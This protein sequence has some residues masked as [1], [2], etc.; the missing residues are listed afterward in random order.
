MA[1]KINSK[2]KNFLGVLKRKF[3]LN[4]VI[5]FGS[6]ARGDA[7]KES[8]YD[9]LIVSQDFKRTNFIDRPRDVVLACNVRFAADLLCYTPDEFEKKRAQISIVKTA[10]EEGTVLF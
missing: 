4:K 6:R 9:F 2:I 3:N 5:L 10:V 7:L 1:A 8:D